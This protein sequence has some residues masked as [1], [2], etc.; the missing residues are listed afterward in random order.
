LGQSA[1]AEETFRQ[2]AQKMEQIADPQTQANLVAASGILAGLQLE[3]AL[4]YRILRRDIMQESAVYRSIWKEAEEE[5]TRA[6]ALNL[7]R[8]GVEISLIASST[9]LSVEAVK[10]LQQQIRHESSQGQS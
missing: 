9:G 4:I 3:E 5:K 1:D 8:G 10:Q 7:L 2:A 6:I